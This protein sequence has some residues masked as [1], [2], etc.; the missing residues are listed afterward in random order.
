MKSKKL[1][2][3]AKQAGF[4]FWEED[5]GAPWHDETDIDWSSDY[6]KEV[7]RLYGIILLEILKTIDETNV[8]SVVFTS[9][10]VDVCKYVKNL[11]RKNVAQKF[12][13]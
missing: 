3:L 7:E 5:E 2:E 10:D 9:Y 6:T 12:G 1:T 8:N 13:E 4:V 11:I